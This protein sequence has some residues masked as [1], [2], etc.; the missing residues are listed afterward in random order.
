MTYLHD[1]VNARSTLRRDV[2]PKLI[3][4]LMPTL[5]TLGMEYEMLKEGQ[6]AEGATVDALLVSLPDGQLPDGY[7]MRIDFVALNKASWKAPDGT[8]TKGP[9]F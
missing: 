7:R 2:I 6:P 3:A 4:A 1:Y 8:P 9:G 5:D